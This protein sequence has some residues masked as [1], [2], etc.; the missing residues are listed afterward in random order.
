MK[1]YWVGTRQGAGQASTQ[2]T[3]LQDGCCCY[4][5]HC[6]PGE[7]VSL[8]SP[9]VWSSATAR[10]QPVPWVWLQQH[11]QRLCCGQE[12]NWTFK[13]L[14]I[15]VCD[16][17]AYICGFSLFLF[18]PPPG[19][20]HPWQRQH[21]GFCLEQSFKALEPLGPVWGCHSL[22]RLLLRFWTL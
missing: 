5:H 11:S 17:I 13:V 3:E 14:Q 8:S 20:L 15:P 16:L 2:V 1:I 18:A 22:Q 12:Q 19:K 21:R 4:S 9:S 6:R 7:P 10:P